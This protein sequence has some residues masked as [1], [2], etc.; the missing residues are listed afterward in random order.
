MKKLIISGV[1]ISA[2]IS[3]VSLSYVFAE[4]K[5]EGGHGHN[6]G[7]GMAHWASPKAAAARVNPIKS[8]QASINRGKQSYFQNCSSCHGANA[9]G[10][11]PLGASLNPKPT[12][13]ASM[14]GMHPDGDFEWKI[15]NGRGPM[16]AW[17]T[18]LNENQRWDLVNYIQALENPNGKGNMAGMDHSNMSAEEMK[19]MMGQVS[20]SHSNDD[21]HHKVEKADDHSDSHDKNHAH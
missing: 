17:K 3:A 11:G 9:M 8:D 14:A 1:A 10:D 12:N 20:S 6:E 2:V 5:H 15:A 21:D 18:F 19:A 7:H 16:P 4:G 13:L